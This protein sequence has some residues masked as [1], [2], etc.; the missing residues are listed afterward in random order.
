MCFSWYAIS[1]GNKN[2]SFSTL[3]TIN[4]ALRD[5]WYRFRFTKE[6]DERNHLF[7]DL[8]N[9]LE[10]ACSAYFDG[11]L[12]HKPKEFLTEYLDDVLGYIQE[13]EE[14]KT[15]LENLRST[16]NA[17]KYVDLY[18]GRRICKTE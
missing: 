1:R 13:S 8:V 15:W 18:I 11:A 2:A 5:A 9:L 7:A 4:E 10:I 12:T 6:E 14:A 17:L 3:V 16:P